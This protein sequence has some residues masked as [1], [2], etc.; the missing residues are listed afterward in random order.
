[1]DIKKMIK[2]AEM[3]QRSIVQAQQELSKIDVTGQ[4]GGGLVEVFMSAQGEIKDL[5]IKKEAVDPDDV[6]TLEDLILSAFKDAT[7]KALSVSQ[8]KLGK[9]T[10]GQGLPPIA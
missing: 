1:M 7:T 9:L 3:L 5:K 10:G 6:E 4:S 2:E 8:E